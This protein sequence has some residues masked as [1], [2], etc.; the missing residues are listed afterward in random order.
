MVLLLHMFLETIAAAPAS[1]QPPLA[2]LMQAFALG[3]LVDAKADVYALLR[4]AE[5]AAAT[6]ASTTAASTARTAGVSPDC[7]PVLS[8]LLLRSAVSAVC[9]RA[10]GDMVAL[11]D[12]FD[13]HDRV[14]NS[15][16][17]GADGN[18]YER[19]WEA[20]GRAELN[21]QD[22]YEGYNEIM[23]P[24]EDEMIMLDGTKAHRSKL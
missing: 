8:L 17:G 7:S 10:W 19:L 18:V 21:K 9:E 20:A 4:P 13:F 24:K 1:L 15:T 2:T 12:A 6:K 14:L 11:T 5:A 3:P 16:I 23:R 22:P